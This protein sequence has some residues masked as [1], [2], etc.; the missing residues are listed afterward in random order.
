LRSYAPCPVCLVPGDKL[1]DL[2]KTFEL[3][4]KGKMREI[5]EQAQKL[6]AADKDDLLKT[7]G[8]MN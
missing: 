5:Y 8:V 6:N 1:A 2:S 3:W 4:T 7:Y